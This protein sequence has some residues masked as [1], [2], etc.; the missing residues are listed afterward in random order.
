MKAALA[1]LAL[2]AVSAP[3]G[4]VLP[5]HEALDEILSRSTVISTEMAS[6]DAAR[7]RAVPVRLKFVPDLVVDSKALRQDYAGPALT[8]KQVEAV[9]TLNLFRFGGDLAGLHAADRDIET[10][11]A[12]VSSQGLSVEE[13]GVEALTGV[14]ER[15]LEVQVSNRIVAMQTENLR[16]ARERYDHGLLAQQEVDK[17][18]V[19]LENARSRETDAVLAA[20]S[21]RQGLEGLLGADRVRIE[22]PWK[23]WF[24]DGAKVTAVAVEEL[25]LEARPDWRAARRRL[26]A[27]EERLTQTRTQILPTVD[28]SFVYGY[29]DGI[30]GGGFAPGIG[31]GS[32]TGWTGTVSATLPLFDRLAAISA[33]RV[34]VATRTT[35]ELALEQL[36]RDA[37][38]EWSAARESFRTSV[39]AA[40]LRERTLATSRRIFQDGLRRFRAGRATANELSVDQ[41]RLLDSELFAVQGWSAAHLAFAR[42][43]HSLG[44]SVWTCAR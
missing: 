22:W 42:L 43:C 32:V 36:E 37:R 4:Q 25:K 20:V 23:D 35:A 17:V 24:S 34:Q 29:Y 10:E 19:D 16:V 21:A 26:D 9:S 7:A 18:S 28:A 1:S 3:A 40:L 2:F 13:N 5:F 39:S 30:L 44:S 12:R 8:G 27:E 41:A 6:L 38:A 15:E 33:A 11:E 14:I 31:N